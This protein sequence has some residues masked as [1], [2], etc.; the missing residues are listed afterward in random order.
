MNPNGRC[1]PKKTT[2]RPPAPAPPAAP[3]GGPVTINTTPLYA[4]M[5]SSWCNEVLWVRADLANNL[6][7]EQNSLG[8]GCNWR[9][10]G[11]APPTSVT[12]RLIPPALY[13]PPPGGGNGARED[14]AVLAYYATHFDSCAP[15]CPNW[16]KADLLDS[17]P[18][19]PGAG[20][21]GV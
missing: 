19:V 15:F 13:V 21:V 12:W 6:Y 3:T 8:T 14:Y 20:R 1:F 2:T 5:P 11:A 17:G 16:P 18:C 10:R 7:C 4:L 9:E